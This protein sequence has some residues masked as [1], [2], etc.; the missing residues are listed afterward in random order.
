MFPPSA[1]V[2]GNGGGMPPPGLMAQLLAAKQGPALKDNGTGPINLQDDAALL[3]HF[4]KA[5]EESFDQRWIYERTWLRNLYY[6]MG[7]QWIFYDNRA[8][9]RDMRLARGTPRPTTS[10][11]TEGVQSIRAMLTAIQL[12][13]NVRPNGRDPQAI[14]T[15]ATADD[16]A[17]ILHD[18]HD[19]NAVL[20]E[21]DGWLIA[22]GNVFYHTYWDKD[23]T[24]GTDTI[25]YETCVECGLSLRADE[26]AD[27]RN[28][29]PTCQGTQ[30]QP[31]VGPDGQPHVDKLPKGCGVTVPLSPLEVAFPLSKPRWKAVDQIIRMS[32]LDKRTAEQTDELKPYV[33]KINWQRQPTDR[34]LQI[35]RAL[36]FHSDLGMAPR[37]FDVGASTNTSEGVPLYDLWAKPSDT[38]PEGLVIRVAG[39]SVPQV[40]R[41]DSQN[42]PGPLPYKDIKGNPLWTFTHAAYE[43]VPGRVLGRGAL[44]PVIGKIDQLNRTDAMLEMQL[45]RTANPYWVYP[46]NAEVTGLEQAGSTVGVHVQFNPLAAGGG[47]NARPR[48]EP[49][50]PI[51]GSV[52]TYREQLVEMIER[53][54]GT[55]DLLKGARPKGVSAFSSLQMLKESGQERFSS[56]FNAR[57]SA[58]QDVIRYA[59]ELERTFGPDERTIAVMS[60]NRAWAF[61]SYKKAQLGGDFTIVLEDGT[62]TPKTTLGR[63]AAI[64][65]AHQLG[66]L[67]FQDPEQ[68]YEGLREMG[69]SGMQP[70]LD[71]DIEDCLNRQHAFEDWMQSGGPQKLPTTLDPV[72]QQ[73]T[74]D[75]HAPEYP[76]RWLPWYDPEISRR[77]C[78]KWAKSDTMRELFK[79]FPPAEKLVEAYLME[80]DIAIQQKAAGQIDPTGLAGI[81]AQPASGSGAAAP[82]SSPGQPSAQSRVPGGASRAM[83]NSNQNSGG[84]H[85]L[86]GGPAMNPQNGQAPI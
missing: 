24:H 68:V 67:L 44:D 37:A 26:I 16:L 35:F 11:P 12:G 59:L 78:L 72:T 10:L 49:G 50:I 54:M 81:A 43:Y 15:A 34:S 45:A 76:L 19:L 3:A 60:P 75:M 31:E 79:K 41:L 77:Q 55:N 8:G 28:T 69:L 46:K 33:D 58:Y 63:R 70:S 30:W 38:Y 51:D 82:S 47:D 27:N 6:I 25:P 83:A 66:L 5:K 71:A 29:C 22:C 21:G 14:I 7:R 61:M 56:M 53:G 80:I 17:P 13:V 65:H 18:I 23:A 73:P 40:L 9:W 1:P 86:P 52:V 36:P 2:N 57:G 39:D 48:R 85:S 62:Q 20:M 74:P 32:W 4:T 42:L 84:L 64:E